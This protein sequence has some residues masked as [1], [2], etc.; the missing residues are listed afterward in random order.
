ME[1]RKEIETKKKKGTERLR[2]RKMGRSARTPLLQVTAA[3]AASLCMVGTMAIR[4]EVSATHI[5]SVSYQILPPVC[6]EHPQHINIKPALT[7]TPTTTTNEQISL[8][9]GGSISVSLRA[10]IVSTPFFP[11]ELQNNI[12]TRGI[13]MEHRT[14]RRSS[15]CS[16]FWCAQ[17]SSWAICSSQGALGAIHETRLALLPRTSPTLPTCLWLPCLRPQTVPT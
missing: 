12:S 11:H 17:T 2:S 9:R 6:T 7:S 14:T 15:T 5:T 4:H 16:R 10:E 8:L 1:R 13:A 3:F